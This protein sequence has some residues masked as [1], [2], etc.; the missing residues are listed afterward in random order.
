MLAEDL[1]TA[2][3]MIRTAVASDAAGMAKLAAEAVPWEAERDAAF[4]RFKGMQD[5]NESE[6][7][8]W[9]RFWASAE[10]ETLRQGNPHLM[11][12]AWSYLG[13][14]EIAN[15]IPDL[16]LPVDRATIALYANYSGL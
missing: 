4:S 6:S 12:P 13:A 5:P 3:G 15:T 11:A 10:S 14:N 1:D 9:V 2:R 16:V 7:L 8:T